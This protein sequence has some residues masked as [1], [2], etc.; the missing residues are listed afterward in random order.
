MQTRMRVYIYGKDGDCPGQRVPQHI[1][2]TATDPRDMRWIVFDGTV[3]ELRELA[4]QNE[5]CGGQYYLR[6]ARTLLREIGRTIRS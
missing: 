5:V 2:D 4:L 3:E 1:I 6:V